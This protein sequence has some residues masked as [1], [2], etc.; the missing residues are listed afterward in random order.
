VRRVLNTPNIAML[1]SWQ[2]RRLSIPPAMQLLRWFPA[3][4]A[5]KNIQSF[6]ISL[7][8]P[9]TAQQSKQIFYRNKAFF[10]RFK[11]RLEIQPEKRVAR[12]SYT[13]A[14]LCNLAV[15]VAS[16]FLGR[17]SQMVSVY[18][19]YSPV[20]RESWPYFHFPTAW[21]VCCR[22]PGRTSCR[23]TISG[24]HFAD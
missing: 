18:F 21:A 2:R 13:W 24:I 12:N 3:R 15:F 23:R 10:P 4:A 17:R 11:L 5:T 7:T 16:T 14:S 19:L 9:F 6:T 1:W 20:L 22:I 8:P